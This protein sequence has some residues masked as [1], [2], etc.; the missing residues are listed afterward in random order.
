M[1]RAISSAALSN[2]SSPLR[3][4]DDRSATRCEDMTFS[5]SAERVALGAKVDRYML[6]G[7]S[8]DDKCACNDCRRVDSV[9]T[10]LS[11]LWKSMSGIRDR[12]SSSRERIAAGIVGNEKS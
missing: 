4:S 6:E 12:T 7:K 9:G 2:V 10:K 5:R 1:A 3:R 8:V 11:G